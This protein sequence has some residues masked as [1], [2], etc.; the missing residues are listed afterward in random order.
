MIPAASTTRR[1]HMCL[2]LNKVQLSK[3]WIGCAVWCS[4]RELVHRELCTGSR[5]T[6]NQLYCTVVLYRRSPVVLF[7][8]RL[9]LALAGSCWLIMSEASCTVV[10]CVL[11]EQVR[12]DRRCRHCTLHR[13]VAGVEPAHQ[14][15]IGSN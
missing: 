9:L 11:G 6:A 1:S 10:L 14:G 12:S 7:A 15:T 8:V 3:R 4:V 2:L 13:S 5:L